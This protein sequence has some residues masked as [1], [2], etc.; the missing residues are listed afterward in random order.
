MTLSWA[1]R[2]CKDITRILLHMQCIKRFYCRV[3]TLPRPIR[4]PTC[5]CIHNTG[6]L[7]SYTV[8]ILGWRTWRNLTDCIP[9]TCN[10]QH[11]PRMIAWCYR[12]ANDGISWPADYTCATTSY[13]VHYVIGRWHCNDPVVRKQINCHVKVLSVLI[14]TVS[15]FLPDSTVWVWQTRPKSY[16]V[17][18]KSIQLL[19][20]TGHRS[21]PQ[22]LSVS[23]ITWAH[24]GITCVIFISSCMLAAALLHLP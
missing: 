18:T 14:R 20:V 7:G 16:S 3:S 19:N 10:M 22:S 11:W 12:T 21:A 2:T 24:P 6:R 4:V 1:V 5:S 23:I 13:T 9:A 15:K 8:D 17:W